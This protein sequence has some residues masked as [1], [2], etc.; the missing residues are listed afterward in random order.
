MIVDQNGAI[1]NE[2]SFREPHQLFAEH[3]RGELIMSGPEIMQHA[4]S[5]D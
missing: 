2:Q 5:G 4:S 3:W 1:L